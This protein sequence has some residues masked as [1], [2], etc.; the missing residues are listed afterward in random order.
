MDRF[1]LP[2][3]VLDKL[4]IIVP[5]VP[6]SSVDAVGYQATVAVGK[7]EVPNVSLPSRLQFSYI[8]DRRNTLGHSHQFDSSYQALRWTWHHR[9]LVRLHLI[10]SCHCFA[11]RIIQRPQ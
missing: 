4:V 11:D 6:Y 1:V 5:A 9:S 10:A 8:P 2:F 3:A 7:L